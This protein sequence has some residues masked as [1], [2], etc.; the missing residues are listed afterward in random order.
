MVRTSSPQESYVQPLSN[1]SRFTT[2]GYNAPQR[3]LHTQPQLVFSSQPQEEY[4]TLEPSR[5]YFIQRCIESCCQG[6]A[7]IKC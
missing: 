5:F 4:N 2:Q 3:H 1:N 6:P 7:H